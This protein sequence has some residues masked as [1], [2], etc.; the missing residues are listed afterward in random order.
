MALFWKFI[1]HFTCLY[2]YYGFYLIKD[3]NNILQALVI[4]GSSTIFK[5]IFYS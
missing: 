5:V 1:L 2:V 4:L 3:R